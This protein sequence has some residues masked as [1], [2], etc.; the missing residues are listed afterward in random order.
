MQI[1]KI[2]Y[3]NGG[4][5][6]SSVPL[7]FGEGPQSHVLGSHRCE[8]LL[9]RPLGHLQSHIEKAC[10]FSAQHLGVVCAPIFSSL[11][12]ALRSHL[13]H[14]AVDGHFHHVQR[15]IG[16]SALLAESDLAS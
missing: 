6:V 5:D 3:H 7:D 8:P 9:V 14:G 10:L 12:G 11:N 15:V 16:A 13:H 1:K 4:D 2:T